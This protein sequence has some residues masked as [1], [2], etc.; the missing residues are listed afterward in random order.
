MLLKGKNTYYWHC[1]LTYNV[2][3]IAIIASFRMSLTVFCKICI[4]ISRWAPSVVSVSALRPSSRMA[5]QLLLPEV[6][7]QM[8]FWFHFYCHILL[9]YT[10]NFCFYFCTHF[11]FLMTL[12]IY[13]YNNLHVISEYKRF[14]YANTCDMKRRHFGSLNF[15][16][17]S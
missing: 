12:S 2:N 15:S 11:S 8:L 14:N 17:Y 10:F 13:A 7:S 9:V 1:K 5:R 3:N 4:V 16:I 6:L